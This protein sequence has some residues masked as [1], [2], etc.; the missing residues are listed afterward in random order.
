MTFHQIDATTGALPGGFDLVYS[1]LFLHHLS[2]DEAAAFLKRLGGAGR[3]VLV[4]DLLRTRL[5]YLLALVAG[6]VLTRSPVVKEDGP[7]SV[8]AAFS[9]DEVRDLTSKLGHEGC[10]GGTLLA[11]AVCPVL[12][13]FVN[14]MSES[15]LTLRAMGTARPTGNPFGMW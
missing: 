11:G 8:K 12:G 9:L 2:D 14:R 5:G 1:S 3:A 4:Q 7:R 6:R 15:M 10:S 13:G